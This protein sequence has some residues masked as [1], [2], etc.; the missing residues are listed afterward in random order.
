MKPFNTGLAL[1]LTVILFYSLCTFA[2]VVWPSQFMEF[3][4]ALFHGLDFRRLSASVPFSWASFF[5]AVVVMGAWAFA[6][7]TFFGWLH[8]ILSLNRVRS[9]VRAG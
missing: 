4:N 8:S 1:S 3:M 7:G 2:E 6:A 5:G 9:A